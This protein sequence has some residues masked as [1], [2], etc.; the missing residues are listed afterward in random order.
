MDNIADIK[1]LQ[2]QFI[3]NLTIYDNSSEVIMDEDTMIDFQFQI[4]YFLHIYNLH[5]V[6]HYFHV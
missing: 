5:Y 2:S 6:L 1:S 3:N 4:K